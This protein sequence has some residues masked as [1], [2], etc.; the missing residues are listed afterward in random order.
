M[1]DSH[2]LI[3]SQLEKAPPYVWDDG[4]ETPRWACPGCGTAMIAES[5]CPECDW[6]DRETWDRTLDDSYRPNDAS[7]ATFGGPA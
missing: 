3:V 2:H 7:L 1:S 6:F 5:H 4:E